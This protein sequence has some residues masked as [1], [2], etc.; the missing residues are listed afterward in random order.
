[1]AFSRKKW[2]AAGLATLFVAAVGMTAGSL[3]SRMIRRTPVPEKPVLD[4][5]LSVGSPIPGGTVYTVDGFGVDLREWVSGRK[6]VLVVLSTECKPCEDLASQWQ[7]AIAV[8]PDINIVIL[9][10]ETSEQIGSFLERH[11]INA[12]VLIDPQRTWV[13]EQRIPAFPVFV[14]VDRSGTIVWTEVGYQEGRNDGIAA[15]IAGM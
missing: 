2:L 3:V 1:M 9:S 15:L 7:D 13:S 12:D 14:A 4:D 6:N 11:R 8:E 10:V 5:R